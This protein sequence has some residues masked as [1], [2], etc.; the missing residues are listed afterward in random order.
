MSKIYTYLQGLIEMVH[1][2]QKRIRNGKGQEREV[3]YNHFVTIGP[4]KIKICQNAFLNLHAVTQKRMR[5]IKHLLKAN[6]TPRDKRGTNPK[7]TIP[8]QE[9]ILIREHIDSFPV[10]QSQYSGKNITHHHN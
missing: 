7:V 8:E 4:K 3:S 10:K 9:N 2:R 1:V 6:L 5:R